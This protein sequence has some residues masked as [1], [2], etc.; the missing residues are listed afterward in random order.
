MDVA[1]AM[2]ELEAAFFTPAFRVVTT[3]EVDDVGFWRRFW[4]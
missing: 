2:V 4:F 3:A 1:T